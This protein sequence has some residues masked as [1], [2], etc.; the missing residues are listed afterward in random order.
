MRAKPTPGFSSSPLQAIQERLR[1]QPRRRDLA[2]A[3][4]SQAAFVAE[5][6]YDSVHST[7]SSD[8]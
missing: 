6:A 2:Q 5:H 8:I 4:G 7:V 3:E 1:Q